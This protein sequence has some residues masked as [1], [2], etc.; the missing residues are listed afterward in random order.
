MRW[1]RILALLLVG[2]L[3]GVASTLGVLTYL[4]RNPETIQK[5][6]RKANSRIGT[7]F[8][9]KERLAHADSELA[10]ANGEYNR[11]VALENAAM[12]NVEAGSPEKAKSYAD[13]L[14]RL[15]PKYSKDWNYGNALHK[16]NLTL[17]R[18]SLR[19]GD[20]ENARKYLLEA[21]RTPGSPQLDSFGP[22]MTL[23]K[24]LLEKGERTAV[25]EYFGLCG[26]FWKMGGQKLREWSA[27]VKDGITPDFGANLRY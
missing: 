10:A 16:G 23:A 2:F 8:D 9:P 21:G 6:I 26:N 4:V 15:A 13:E 18:L 27:L 24:E 12:M 19:S 20:L 1:L 22:N 17:G 7:S 14:L 11:W 3:V 25:L 5:L